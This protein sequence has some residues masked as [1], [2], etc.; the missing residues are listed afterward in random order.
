MRSRHR[1]L[2][3]SHLSHTIVGCAVILRANDAMAGK[4]FINYRREDSIGTAG[5]LFDRLA[6]SFGRN[7]LFMDIDH[8]PAGVDFV[9]YLNGQVAACD[10]FLAVIGPNWL[11]IKD[12]SG[13]RRLDSPD[14]F[15][16]IEIAAALARNIR[17]IPVLVDGALPPDSGSLPEMVKPLVRRQAIEV[18]NA[19][20]GRDADALADKV[21]EAL[22][23]QRTM[24]TRPFVAAGLT[25]LLLLVGFGTYQMGASIWP[26]WMPGATQPVSR[27]ADNAEAQRKAE[28]AERQRLAAVKEEDERKA[29]AAAKLEAQRKVEEAE[30]QRLAAVKEEDERKAIA[31]A[32]LEAQRK[33]EEAERQRL[34]AVKEEDERKA[35]AA[36]KL[37]AQRKAEEAERQ[38]LAAA[39]GP[40]TTAS[41][42]NWSMPTGNYANQRYS[43]LKQIT[44]DNVGKLQVAW[45][46]STG[47]SARP[48]RRPADHRQHDV[49]PYAVPEHRVCARPQSTKAASSGSTS[50]SRIPA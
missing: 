30:R 38:R 11:N 4:I 23:A 44:A 37:E 33:V 35:I 32:K 39:A 18:R 34:A 2:A 46:F 19:Q 5:R 43:A 8:I 20:F 7:N 31:A 47:V 29:I 10:V 16:R 9:D 15:V 42:K 41:Q 13:R 1:P 21:R 25:A 48:R 14:D 28:E 17:V 50:R 26:S 40:S 24:P 22:K 45:T 49:R 12:E 27:S 36:A 6:G 3:H